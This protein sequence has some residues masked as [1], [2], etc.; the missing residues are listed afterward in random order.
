[1]TIHAGTAHG[2]SHVQASAGRG[3][4]GWDATAPLDE[5]LDWLRSRVDDL[6]NQISTEAA[7]RRKLGSELRQ[8]VSALASQHARD[9]ADIRRTLDAMAREAAGLDARAFLIVPFGIILTGLPDSVVKTAVGSW[10][11]FWMGVMTAVGGA[12]ILTKQWRVSRR[13]RLDDS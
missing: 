12:Y 5:R 13:S 10:L 3:Y 11:L 1:V 8:S 7:E 4:K 2:A 9:V 6:Q